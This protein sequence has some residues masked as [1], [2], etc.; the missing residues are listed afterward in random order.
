MH[1]SVFLKERRRRHVSVGS[2]HDT[3]GRADSGRGDAAEADASTVVMQTAPGTTAAEA[4]PHA[5]VRA[6]TLVAHHLHAVVRLAP[7]N[8][9]AR[10]CA[11][12]RHA[13]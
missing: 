2:T 9:S 7:S 13:V 1:V 10:C 5:M 3:R 8:H 11:L 12:A 4:W 6:S